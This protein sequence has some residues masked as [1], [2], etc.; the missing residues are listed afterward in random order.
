MAEL[1]QLFLDMDGVLADFDAGYIDLFGE[2][3]DRTAPDR[4][5][6]W[7][8]INQH[9]SFY[10]SLE[11]LPDAR[12]LW[13]FASR[14]RPIILTGVPKQVPDA[15]THKRAWARNHFGPEAHVITC[16]SKD[17][18]L[19][20]KPGDV[21]VDDWV[22]YRDRWTGMGGIWVTHTSAGDSISKLK[23]LGY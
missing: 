8:R 18:C 17:K 12:E 20:G 15:A 11:P 6:M 2:A 7:K 13:R 3:P 21:L 10:Y 9:G 16:P 19:H 5:D 1:G 4:P 23:E 22:K 14:H